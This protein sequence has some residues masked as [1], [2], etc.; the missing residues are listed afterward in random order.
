MKRFLQKKLYNR[1]QNVSLAESLLEF[2]GGGHHTYRIDYAKFPVAVHMHWP[3]GKPCL[4][5]NMYLLEDCYSSTGDSVV[6][7]ASKLTQLIRYCATGRP[8]GN[9]CGFQ[10]LNDSDVAE[11]V[12]K[13][14]AET[15]LDQP[16]LKVRNNNTVR[17]IM[18]TVFDFLDWYQN[19]LNVNRRK[20]I[21]LQKEGAAITVKVKQN[22]Q[23]GNTY[24]YHRH[25]PPKVSTD[26]KLPI[27]TSMIE[28]ITA[29]IDE[30]ELTENYSEPGLRRFGHDDKYLREYLAYQ[31]ARRNFMI[32][33]M[34]TTGLRPE[35]MARISVSKN[36]KSLRAPTPFLILPTMKRRSL[37]PPPR[38]FPLTA[39]QSTRIILYLRARD[40]W[41]TYCASLTGNTIE[42]DAM[43]L[44]VGPTKLGAPVGKGAL[45]KDFKTLCHRAGFVNQQACFSMFRHKFITDLVEMNLVKYENQNSV[46][47]KQDY[48]TMLEK[49][50][51]K[52]GHKSIDSLWRYIDLVR[53]MAGVWDSVEN[54]IKLTHGAE[55]LNFELRELLKKLK[56]TE[57]QDTMTF[58][59]LF[60]RFEVPIR[61]FLDA[62]KNSRLNEFIK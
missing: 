4:A 13:L 12:K 61:K 6:A 22:L 14:C 32:F 53:G 48:R 60:N 31:S 49:I 50:R 11:M 58:D 26:P 10:D 23:Y 3:T 52:T 38:N 17:A 56:I 40:H 28:A 46:M 39:D 9:P 55:Q 35:E 19:N 27:S 5:I 21:G 37:E 7:K 45:Q 20:L 47:S 51:E 25:L 43:F 24:F 18:H 15:R 8:D 57:G 59:Q 34:R 16:T 36:A 1:L 30:L 2:R 33:M 42:T 44:S 62:G 41:L 29:M 54:I